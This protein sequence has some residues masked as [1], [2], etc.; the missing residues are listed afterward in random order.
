MLTGEYC[1]TLSIR[2]R[3]PWG[4]WRP[5]PE[6]QRLSLLSPSGPLT[7]PGRLGAGRQVLGKRTQRSKLCWG[8]E[9]KPFLS[10]KELAWEQT[11][12]SFCQICPGY[13][14]SWERHRLSSPTL[15]SFI[16]QS[17]SRAGS[18]L[19]GLPRRRGHRCLPREPPKK[20]TQE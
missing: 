17:V 14:G 3:E 8:A 4:C 7:L 16:Q 11:V 5:G 12:G 19:Y 1:A 13:G 15:I 9:P 18:Q 6:A 20:Q 2:R 10:P